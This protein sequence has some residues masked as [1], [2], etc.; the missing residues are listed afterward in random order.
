MYP[1]G[2]SQLSHISPAYPLRPAKGI[3]D[4]GGQ[5]GK[6]AK[7]LFGNFHAPRIINWPAVEETS[8]SPPPPRNQGYASGILAGFFV[9]LEGYFNRPLPGRRDGLQASILPSASAA[10]CLGLTVDCSVKVCHCLF[11][12]VSEYLVTSGQLERLTTQSFFVS[13]CLQQL[14]EGIEFLLISEN[15][16]VKE[17][18]TIRVRANSVM[19]VDSVFRRTYIVKSIE[20]LVLTFA[21]PYHASQCLVLVVRYSISTR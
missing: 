10:C 20:S 8:Y 2:A 18:T 19:E 4:L 12:C 16:Q 1:C 14:D 15:L 21:C 9:M 17:G 11:L 7:V 13:T 6:P 3:A 5:A